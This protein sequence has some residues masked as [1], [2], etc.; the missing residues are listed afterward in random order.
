MGMTEVPCLFIEDLTEAQKRAYIIA[1]NKLALDAGWDDELLRIEIG[2]LQA[3]DFDVSLTGFDLADFEL[4]D[5]SEF[6]DF[7][8]ELSDSDTE[9]LERLLNGEEE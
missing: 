7:E 5:Y 1:D 3:M 4:E 8:A 9:Y 6:K 2:E